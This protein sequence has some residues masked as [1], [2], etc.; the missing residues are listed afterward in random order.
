MRPPTTQRCLKAM[1][2]PLKTNIKTIEFYFR[3]LDLQCRTPETGFPCCEIEKDNFRDSHGK[4][5]R[6]EN[7]E[8]FES[9]VLK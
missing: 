2:F 9:K 3:G 6:A 8:S 4:Q 5:V 1:I 7:K